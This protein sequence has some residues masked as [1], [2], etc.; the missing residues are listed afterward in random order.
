MYNHEKSQLRILSLSWKV[1]NN[2]STINLYILSVW[3]F[4]LGCFFPPN[5]GP[6]ADGH[7][8][9]AVLEKERKEMSK[10]FNLES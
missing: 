8:A 4:V 9:A 3:V 1:L 5:T 10:N 7:R 2:L 6:D